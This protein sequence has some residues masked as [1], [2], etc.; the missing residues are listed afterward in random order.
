MSQ[1]NVVA[2]PVVAQRMTGAA[3]RDQILAAART[4][5]SARGYTASTDEVAR[6]A[7]VSQP[8]VVRLFGSK[9]ELFVETYR[10]ASAQVLAALRSVEPGPDA[11]RLMGDAYVG[12]L[13]DRELLLL[14]MHGFIAGTDDEVGRIA[15]HTLGE[16]F[17]L[18]REASGADENTARQFVAQGMLINVLLAV[19]AAEHTGEDPGMDALVECTIQAIEERNA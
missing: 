6:A 5:F 3:R 4:V 13:A 17:R 11:G 10:Q 18:F 16:A 12:L 15:R 7:G 14:L 8:Y 2:E 19:G 9:R 1:Q